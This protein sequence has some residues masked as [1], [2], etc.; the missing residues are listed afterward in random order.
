MRT[1][2]I[3]VWTV[4]VG[5]ILTSPGCQCQF[6]TANLQN[7]R[8]AKDKDGNQPTTV[9]APTDTF[10]CV[11]NLANAPDDTVVKSVWTA[12]KVAGDTPENHKIDEAEIKQGS[13]SVDFKL[14]MPN[15][16]P[17]GKYKVDLYLNGTLKQTLEFEVKGE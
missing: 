10:H 17:V 14:S 6:S 16:W 11:L 13:G 1:L 8:M 9:F 7:V 3:V 12:V 2:R 4:L 15:P 5:G